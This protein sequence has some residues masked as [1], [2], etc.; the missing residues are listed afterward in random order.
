[1]KVNITP[2]KILLNN[3]LFLLIFSLI[4]AYFTI[5]FFFEKGI[6]QIKDYSQNWLTLDP[7]WNIS[8]AK[9]YINNLTWGEDFALTYGPLGFLT[10]RMLLGINKYYLLGFDLFVTL[11][12]FLF[13]YYSLLNASSKKIVLLLISLCLICLPTYF[14]A[15][16]SIILLVL[17][18]FWMREFLTKQNT[19]SLA[20]AMLISLLLL[21]MKFNTGFISALLLLS[22]INYTLITQPSA[23]KR[24]LIFTG[25]YISLF[26]ILLFLLNVSVLNYFK[27]GFMMIE[28]YSDIM[29]LNQEKYLELSFGILTVLISLLCL[30]LALKKSKLELFEGLYVTFLFALPAYIFYKQGFTRADAQHIKEFYCYFPLLLLAFPDFLRNELS[31]LL[32]S[33][34]FVVVFIC[35]FFSNKFSKQSIGNTLSRFDKSGY[36]KSF[37]AYSASSGIFLDS[38]QNQLP[39]AIKNK[40][41]HSSIDAY[42][43]NILELFENNLNI[44]SRPVI[45]SYTAYTPQLEKLNAAFYDSEKAPDYVLYDYASIDN[46]YPLCDE[47]LLHLRLFIN[48]DVC[49]T[50]QSYGR[51][52]LLLKKNSKNKIKL[53]EVNSYE[54]NLNSQIIPKEDSYYEVF[55]KKTIKGKIQSLLFNPPQLALQ[56]MNANQQLFEYHTSI[57]LLESGFFSNQFYRSTEDVYNMYTHKLSDKNTQVAYYGFSTLD[58][59][60]FDDKIMVKEYKIIK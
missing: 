19:L 53:Q 8:I 15:G 57:K 31:P 28:G 29:H 27:T 3:K 36:I 6:W 22:T 13:F 4:A 47:P 54:A 2:I 16:T 40:I 58:T 25:I 34:P 7:S 49:D 14:G 12:I 9:A 1:M 45:Q 30:I 42:P 26:C 24:L 17:Q 55:I 33:A 51:F 37:N 50:L 59:D 11:N 23:K 38:T 41:S 5:P 10:T 32:K 18:S 20:A 56:V 35:C 39:L 48:Y 46:R 21:F 43:W 52:K 44:A 60:C